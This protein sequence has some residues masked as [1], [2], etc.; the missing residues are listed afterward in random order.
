M[1]T[2]PVELQAGGQDAIALHAGGFGEVRK[3]NIV[4]RFHRDVR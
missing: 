2:L 3:A 1:D 4:T